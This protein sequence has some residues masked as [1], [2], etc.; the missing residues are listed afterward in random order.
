MYVD[1]VSYGIEMDNSE[2]NSNF[3]REEVNPINNKEKQLQNFPGGQFIE[4]P[5]FCW[6]NRVRPWCVLN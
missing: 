5:I 2:G 3:K 4:G 6:L 1:Y